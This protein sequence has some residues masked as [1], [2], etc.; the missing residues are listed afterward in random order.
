MNEELEKLVYSRITEDIWEFSKTLSPEEKEWLSKIPSSIFA[1]IYQAG[2][3][4][5]I[6]IAETLRARND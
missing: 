6:K 2:A 5:T 4:S 3:V 1:K